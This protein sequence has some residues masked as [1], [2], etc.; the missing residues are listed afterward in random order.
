[1]KAVF[2]SDAHLPADDAG[3]TEALKDFLKHVTREA[4]L[5]VVLGDLFEFYHGYDGYIYPFYKEIVDT[6]R[7]IARGRP[8]YFI[9][10]NHEFGMGQFFE[11]YTGVSCVTSLAL[12][13]DEKR[14][15]LCHGDTVP[16]LPL[17]RLL[18]SRLIYAI[19][20]LLGPE[21]TWRIAMQFRR[22]FSKRRRPR[23]EKVLARY[24]KYGR[25]KLREGY[26]AVVIAHSHMA[27]LDRYEVNGVKKTYMNTGNLIE[28]C[29]Y[30]VYITEKGF[31]LKTYDRRVS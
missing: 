27:D 4:D 18:R 5:V 22:L 29:T 30:G 21:R 26:D 7:D 13:M 16:A 8:V 31:A 1:M 23:S 9:E 2:F 15:F 12:N 6:L 24:R 14:V 20:D 19:M 25:E 10:G 28:S 17:H 3:R 11:S